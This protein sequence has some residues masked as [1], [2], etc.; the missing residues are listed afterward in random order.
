MKKLVFVAVLVLFLPLIAG[1][2]EAYPKAEV[3]GGYSYFRL[4]DPVSLIDLNLHGWNASVSGNVNNWLGIVG[5][6]SGHYGGPEAFGIGV[7]FLDV[8]THSF[9][10]G[11]RL[12]YRSER[13]TPFAHF[14]IGATRGST[15]LFGVSFSRNALSGAIGGGLDLRVSRNFAV[16]VIQA[17]Y[18]MTRF[19]DERQNNMRLSAGIVF[20]LGNR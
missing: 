10:V 19:F 6:F 18:L 16:R 15:G 12:S 5:D 7:P 1:A 11:P 14:L 9:M 4:D 20:L 17:D 13:V 3:F 8:N 2:Q